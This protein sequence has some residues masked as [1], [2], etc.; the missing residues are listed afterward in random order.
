MRQKHKSI[1]VTQARKELANIFG[2]VNYHKERILLTN[3]KKRVA[4][5]P[6]ED[7]EILESLEAAEDI[8]EAKLALK[9]IEEEGTI[10]LAEMKRG[11]AGDA[12][13]ECK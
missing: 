13:N 2:E 10:S 9:E 7:L 11:L 8:R 1:S 6:I 12:K 3:H 5:V 4:I